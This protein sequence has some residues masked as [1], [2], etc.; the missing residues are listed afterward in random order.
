MRVSP[1]R[2]RRSGG[3]VITRFRA[4][5]ITSCGMVIALDV[6]AVSTSH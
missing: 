6:I 2:D 5:V 4:I 1:H 3:I